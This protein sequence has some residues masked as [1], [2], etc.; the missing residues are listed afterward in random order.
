LFKPA[1]PEQVLVRDL[2]VRA[3]R[4]QEPL[5]VVLG[6]CGLGQVALGAQHLALYHSDEVVITAALV[7]LLL[8][9]LEA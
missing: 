1:I 3:Q 5:K 8:L 7:V 4:I 9:L 6:R 2:V